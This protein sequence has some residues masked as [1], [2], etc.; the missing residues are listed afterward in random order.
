[1]DDFDRPDWALV[2]LTSL[3]PSMV[4]RGGPVPLEPSTTL[5]DETTG[6]M[7]V[8]HPWGT[9][10]KISNFKGE[11]RAMIKTKV[12]YEKVSRLY[13]VFKRIRLF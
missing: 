2:R 10:L 11:P 1:M 3:G 9:A 4:P 12:P 5:K 8:G 13:L 7:I 6:V